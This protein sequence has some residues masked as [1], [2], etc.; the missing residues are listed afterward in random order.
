MVADHE[1]HMSGTR[2]K[3]ASAP[4]TPTRASPTQARPGLPRP[5]S[6]PA[7]AR[8]K[9]GKHGSYASLALDPSAS[10]SSTKSLRHRPSVGAADAPGTTPTANGSVLPF[11]PQ[12]TTPTPT[13]TTHP[14]SSDSEATLRLKSRVV[15]LGHPSDSSP[16]RTA[17]SPARPSGVGPDL[18]PPTEETPRSRSDYGPRAKEGEMVI[19]LT[20][21]NL[22]VLLDYV[23]QCERR[24]DEWRKRADRLGVSA[25]AGPSEAGIMA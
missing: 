10:P 21:E 20:P 17:S 9:N 6:V 23:Q 14:I 7:L 8:L 5:P 2:G 15:G 24:L 12:P 13:S 22:P 1:S 3:E 25:P 4:A 16:A 18:A 11:P 19:A